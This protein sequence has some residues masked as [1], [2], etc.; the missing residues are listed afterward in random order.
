MAWE[1]VPWMVAG[2]NHSAEVG[3][4]LAYAATAGAEGVVGPGDCKVVAS[5]IPD[6]NI[7]IN[8][9]AIGMLNR[10]PGGTAQSYM[11][12]NVGDEVKALTPQGS[13]GVRYDLV[14]VIVEDPQYAGQ[15][16]PPSVPNGPYLRTVVYE[17][18][19]NTTKALSEV[20]ADQTGY[21][22][23]LVKFDASDGTVTTADI[24]DLR[25]LLAPR[26]QTVK[27]V[28]NSN[29]TAAFPGAL[30]A[31]PAAASWNVKIPSWASKVQ[32]EARWS[33]LKYTDTSSGAGNASGTARVD[34]GTLQSQTTQW[35]ED[36]TASNKPVTGTVIVGDELDVPAGLRGTIQALVAKLAK[37]GGAGMTAQTTPYTTVVVEATFYEALI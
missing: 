14:A 27:K 32:L 2:G 33:G 19:P 18:V 10:F 15:P 37:T 26:V 25:E 28:L 9:G 17:N 22:L 23:A 16:A 34:L 4:L 31:A 11:V 30:G 20:D 29:A 5:A 24:T 7:H 36:A 3:R 12:R 6:G 13:S 8:P 35:L 21:A 1:G